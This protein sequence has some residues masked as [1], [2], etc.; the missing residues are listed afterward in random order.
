MRAGFDI[1]SRSAECRLADHRSVSFGK[2]SALV[3]RIGDSSFVPAWWVP[4]PHLQ[5]VWGK[6]VRRP[7][8]VPTRTERWRTPDGDDL[9]IRRLP[10]PDP[11]APRLVLLHGLEGTIRSHY[12][13]GMLARCQ[14]IGWAANVLIFRSCNGVVPRA[15]RMYHSGET[16]DLDFVV[17]RLIDESSDR[18]ILLAG[19]SLGGNVLLKW[20]GEQGAAA[21]RQVVAAA[22]VSVPFDLERGARQIERGAARVYTKHFLQTLRQK[23]LAKLS[24]DPGAFDAD[25]LRAATSLFE[26][27]DAVT[28]PLHG[29]ASAHDYYARSSA[30]RFLPSIRRSTLLL[31][32]RDDPFLPPEVLDDVLLVSQGNAC[33]RTDF[34]AHGGH[35]GFVAGRVPG[36]PRYWA[37][38]RVIGYLAARVAD[39][40]LSTSARC[41]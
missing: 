37:E 9:E 28:A 32:A 40:A 38:R 11:Q 24:A 39:S 10:S 18:P 23:A 20:L 27:D 33:L 31:S 16:T 22:A 6:L 17:R 21:P 4:G 15:P 3:T 19:F 25:R 8:Q 2:S 29:F 30:L 12:L 1:E 36:R 14:E 7:A 34:P 41:A 13:Q 5:T 35:V 26:F